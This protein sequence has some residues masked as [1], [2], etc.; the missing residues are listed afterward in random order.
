MSRDVVGRN[1][2]AGEDEVAQAWV[3]IDGTPH[4]VPDVGLGLPLIDQSRSRAFQARIDRH[5]LLHSR[6]RVHE[7]FACRRLPGRRGLAA[8]PR[9]LDHDS[10]RCREPFGQFTV[11]DSGTIAGRGW[12]IG[13]H[14]GKYGKNDRGFAT[15]LIVV[16]Q[17]S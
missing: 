4:V 14:D 2:G 10:S 13:C 12:G 17:F 6:I 3:V 1:G 15:T 5:R 8:D 9:P 16:L 11:G 7:Y